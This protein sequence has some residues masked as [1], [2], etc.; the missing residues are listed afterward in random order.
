MS[1]P[2]FYR[3]KVDESGKRYKKKEFRKD[4]QSIILAN[5]QMELRQ[6]PSSPPPDYPTGRVHTTPSP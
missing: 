4:A 1:I 2:C 3:R 5:A 6:I